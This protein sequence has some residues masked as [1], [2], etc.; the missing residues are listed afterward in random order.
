MAGCKIPGKE[1]ISD[2]NQIRRNAINMI[3]CFCQ[4]IKYE[5]P[6]PVSELLNETHETIL[7]AQKR[8]NLITAPYLKLAEHKKRWDS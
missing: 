5:R 6:F 7:Q 8:L 1:K 3:K 2:F 4:K